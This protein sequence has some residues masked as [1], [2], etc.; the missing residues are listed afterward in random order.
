MS[1]TAFLPGRGLLF[2]IFTVSGFSGL[3]YESIWS[4]YL[5]LLLGHAA[6]AQT[7]VLAIFMG[8]MAV[9]A[10]L[11]ARFATRL[12]NLLVGYAMVEI[13]TGLFALIFHSVYVG[14]ID[15]SFDKA[16]PALSNG[17]AIQAY[18]WTLA[19]LLILPQS[20]LLGTTFPL[21]SGGVIR[22]FPEQ[23]GA[24][25]ATLYFTNSIGAA[26]GVLASGFFLIGRIGL[27]GT[28]VTAGILNVLLGAFVWA[29]ARDT[30]DPPPAAAVPATTAT[31]RWQHWMLAIAFVAGVASF[32]Y[33]IAWIRMLSMVLGSSTHAFELMLSAFIAGLAFG[34][35][36][37]RRRIDRIAK[38]LNAL[39]IMFAI[40]AL[41]A[42]ITVPAYD[43]S[44]S[45]MAAA[46]SAFAPTPAGYAG[47]NLVSHGIAAATMFP[48][49]FVAGMALPMLTKVLMTQGAGEAAIGRV[50]AL[51]TL[52]AIVGSLVTIHVL[53]GAVGL[54][55]AVMVGAL[56][57][58]AVA[59]VLPLLDRDRS[60]APPLRFAPAAVSAVCVLAIA[61]FAH[62]D[63]MRM[64]AG[65]YRHGVDRLPP[66]ARVTYLRDGKTATISLHE[67]QDL[68]TIS[69]NGKPDASINMKG[70]LATFDEVT[71]TMAAALPL[72]MH[73]APRRVANIGIGSGLTSHVILASPE[74]RTL[75]SIEIEAAIVEAAHRGFGARVR[76]L[77]EDP[78]SH[79]HVEDAKTWF[80]SA[81]EP[82][83]IIISEPSNPWIS[84][85]ATLFSDEFYGHVSRYLKPNG[86]LVQWVQIYE[87]DVSIVASII[88]A[89]SPHFADYALYNTDDSNLLIVATRE[90]SLPPLD[91]RVFAA[92]P[93]RAELAL[94]DVHRVEDMA[95]R[96]IGTRAMLEPLFASFAVPANS[97]YR[98][99]VDLNAP[100][101]RFL[102]REGLRLTELRLL[103]SPIEDLLSDSAPQLPSPVVHEPGYLQRIVYT[104]RAQAIMDAMRTG[105]PGALDA[106]AVRNLLELRNAPGECADPH[107]RNVWL[108]A[109]VNVAN[110]TSPFLPPSATATFWDQLASSDCWAKLA[111]RETALVEFM[112]AVARRDRPSVVS[113]GM[114]MLT[115]PEESLQG[116]LGVVMSTA[117][118]LVATGDGKTALGLMAGLDASEL[119]AGRYDLAAR[120]I[121][122]R[123]AQTM[124]LKLAEY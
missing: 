36:W 70:G 71:M 62:L 99:F 82:Y 19:S 45:A 34:G 110:Q 73:P 115:D 26:C 6:Y 108:S 5:K 12:R 101:M 51:N 89:L 4:H 35:L 10:W 48:T 40:M 23:P 112:R 50:Y 3:I 88:K 117:S 80:A 105:E 7:L 69:T 8:G 90:G 20:I 85:V 114:K 27:H 57:Q 58:L 75:D 86:L 91:A 81:S 39:A 106:G 92:A 22:R 93:L 42:A 96:R 61:L 111:P 16:I 118:A 43:L 74:V 29:V 64:A 77:Y 65:V 94:V 33:E 44:F 59:F 76:N 15:F 63:P 11:A 52:G 121:A 24:T 47:F 21:I 103:S 95:I 13:L 113:L 102:K 78:R 54:K 32:V 104:R 56:L 124:N 46:M 122:A 25:L 66:S 79:I 119:D 83:D 109:V 31:L 60:P 72:S 18:K 38:P 2:A 30:P 17:G 100:K 120:W 123:A 37:I 41:T 68:V 1:Q 87:T 14:A 49:S 107:V 28:V 84:G 116:S 67:S 55:G 98:P 53:F 97:D 9:G